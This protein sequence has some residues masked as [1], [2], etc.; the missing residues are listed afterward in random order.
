[1]GDRASVD[2]S[3]NIQAQSLP[4]ADNSPVIQDSV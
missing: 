2:G 1:M 3:A 4:S